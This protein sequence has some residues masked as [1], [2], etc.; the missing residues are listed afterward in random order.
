MNEQIRPFR[1]DVPQTR[2]DD[3]NRRLDAV[4]RDAMLTNVMTYW[5]NGTAGSSARYYYEG[6]ATWG[7]PEPATAVPVAVAVM[8]RDIG[9][10]IRR[11]AEQNHHIVRWTEFDRGGH[12]AAMEEPDLII[13]DLRA[14]LRDYRE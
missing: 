13:D 5:L 3:L 11:L 4:R 1:I 7:K 14:T 2:L 6:A 9:A 12:F 10:P 8:P